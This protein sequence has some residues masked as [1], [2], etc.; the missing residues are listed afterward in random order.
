MMAHANE[1]GYSI[2]AQDFFSEI[3]LGVSPP[4][5]QS[6]CEARQKL[7]Y[8]AF[9]YLLDQAYR[10]DLDKRWHGFHG[11]LIADGTKLNLPRTP[12]LLAHCEAPNNS[13]GPGHY[14]QALMV[15][16]INSATGQ[17]L[18]MQ[19]G[20]YRESER[21]LLLKCLTTSKK[22]DLWLLDRGLGGAGIYYEFLRQEIDFIHRMKTWG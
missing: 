20:N 5:K 12:D 6:L 2:T 11:V 13:A 16:V 10:D 19:I 14:P 1:A 9:E 8:K 17:P 21:A 15:T 7:S 18:G 4:C 22:N 3:N